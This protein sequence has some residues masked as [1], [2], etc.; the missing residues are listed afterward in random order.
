MF[1]KWKINYYITENSFRSG[2]PAFYETISGDRN[3][4]V[5]WAQNKIKHSQFEFFDIQQL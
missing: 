2:V 4:V 1:M 5:N 3:F